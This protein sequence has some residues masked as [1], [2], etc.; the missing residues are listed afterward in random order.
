MTTTSL[1][2]RRALTRAGQI[3]ML[4][5]AYARGKCWPSTV[6]GFLFPDKT[7]VETRIVE[8]LIEGVRSNLIEA[9]RLRIKVDVQ[10]D[11]HLSDSIDSSAIAGIVRHLVKKQH[12]KIAEYL[13]VKYHKDHMDEAEVAKRFGDAT[14]HY[15]HHNDDLN[16]V[17][18]FAISE[19][20]W[21]HVGRVAKLT[22]EG[23]DE[24]SS[25]YKIYLTD[26]LREPDT[27]WPLDA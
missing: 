5:H 25:G 11:F 12:T 1:F 13:G 19:L 15:K 23:S 4:F 14:W 7:K 18:E 22:G 6:S 21:Y 10:V 8:N 17:A 16:H 2:R 26:F 3:W 20:Q 27:F 24:I 9:I